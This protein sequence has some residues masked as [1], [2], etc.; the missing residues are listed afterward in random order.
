M[1][2]SSDQK[3]LFEA[4]QRS[5]R[6]LPETLV[7]KIAAGEVIDRPSSVVKELVENSLDAGATEIIVQVKEGGKALIQVTDNGYGMSEEDAILA[8]ERHATSKIATVEDLHNIRTLGFRGE[9]LASIASVS[10]VELR[11]RRPKDE[12]GTLLKL[13]GGRLA[14]VQK[15]GCNPGTSIAVKNLFFNTPARRKFLKSDSAEYRHI[16]EVLIR[17]ALAYPQVAFSLYRGEQEVFSYQPSDPKARIGEIFGKRY[18]ENLISVNFRGETLQATGFIGSQDLFRQAR[19]EQFLFLNRRYITHRGL[20]HAVLSAYGSLLPQGLFPFYVL[21][22]QIDPHQVDVNVHPTKIEVRFED[23]QKAYRTVHLA[24]REALASFEA[25]PI[26]RTP[27]PSKEEQTVES[28]PDQ[29]ATLTLPF[30]HLPARPSRAYPLEEP[31]AEGEP[32]EEVTQP[33][34]PAPHLVEGKTHPPARLGARVEARV[35]VWQLH[36]KYILSQI[37]SGLLIIDQHLAHERVLYEK[38]L[39]SF[40]RRGPS[41]QQQLFPKTIQLSQEDY[42]ILLEIQYYLNKLGFVVKE[43]GGRTVVVEAVPAELRLGDEEQLL[44][45]IIDAYKEGEETDIRERVAKSYACRSAIKA[46]EPLTPE[47]M[48]AL[49]DDLFATQ[50]PYFCPH[51]RP[52]VVTIPIEELDKRFLRL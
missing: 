27:Q 32:G 2:S 38:A 24:V 1:A 4:S 15:I 19:G 50:N 5:I 37:K 18:P 6:I 48:A 31:V 44:R 47:E 34:E 33:G 22:L 25:V 36:N 43:F 20:H 39:Q 42:L 49:I 45:E 28:P 11:T 52:I 13:E 51:G 23:E 10:R 35:T 9:A 26:L 41:A 29:P 21:Y 30:T 8:F 46:G 12:E 7:N 14:S 40:E 17:F 3:S 16:V